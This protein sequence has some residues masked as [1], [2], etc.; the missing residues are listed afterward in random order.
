MNHYNLIIFIGPIVK[1]EEVFELLQTMDRVPYFDISDGNLIYYKVIHY[2]CSEILVCKNGLN[3]MTSS[4]N[5]L[6]IHYRHM[7]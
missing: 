3:Y 7:V 2:L 6:P 1:L 4:I 5:L